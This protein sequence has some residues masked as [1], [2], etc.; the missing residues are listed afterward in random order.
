[1]VD[2]IAATVFPLIYED[3]APPI[4]GPNYE[5]QFGDRGL[6]NFVQIPSSFTRPYGAQS[7]PW[8]NINTPEDSDARDLDARDV[9]LHAGLE[10]VF[11]SNEYDG[12]EHE[13]AKLSSPVHKAADSM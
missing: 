7:L 6:D 11:R 1:V 9:V 8:A 13:I 3:L 5:I 2:E 12:I 4:I 10:S